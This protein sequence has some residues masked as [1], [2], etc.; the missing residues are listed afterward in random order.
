MNSS[1]RNTSSAP[2]NCCGARSKP[3]ACPP[4]FCPA[5]PAPAKPRSLMSSPTLPRPNSNG[6]LPCGAFNSCQIL[7]VGGV[8]RENP[9]WQSPRQTFRMYFKQF[10]LN[11]LAHASYLIGSDGEAV[12]VDP[13]RDVDRVS[14]SLSCHLIRRAAEGDTGECRR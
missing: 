14:A 9:A 1:A 7:A 11:C 3:I 12:V 8:L 2:G 13:Q 4:S 5:R 10:Y 6:S